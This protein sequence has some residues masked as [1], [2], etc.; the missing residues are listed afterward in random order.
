VT[1]RREYVFIVTPYAKYGKY[2][3]YTKYVKY[4]N[5]NLIL[6]DA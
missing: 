1:C 5:Q 6:Q 3:Q 4:A 2:G